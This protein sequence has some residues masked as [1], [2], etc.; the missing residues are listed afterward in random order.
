MVAAQDE[1]EWQDQMM[2][3]LATGFALLLES[4]CESFEILSRIIEGKTTV[5]SNHYR[6]PIRIQMALAKDFLFFAARAHR[7]CE[8]G[9]GALTLPRQE[10]IR[11]LKTVGAIRAVRDVNEHGFDA[12]TNA[13]PS[14]HHQAG[15]FLDE[16][17]LAVFGPEQVL[18]G[19]L[20]LCNIYRAVARMRDIAGFGKAPQ[21]A[22]PAPPEGGTA[23]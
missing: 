11:F 15:G 7:V 20:N 10:R 12:N 21:P 17:A 14:L 22:R 18:M 1:K 8:H 19:P 3:D 9:S 13:K 5:V 6:D 23:N 16:T 2:H 4:A